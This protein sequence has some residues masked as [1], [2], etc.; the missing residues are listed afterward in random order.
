MAQS[1][2]QVAISSNTNIEEHANTKTIKMMTTSQILSP[3]SPLQKLHTMLILYIVYNFIKVKFRRNRK[4]CPHPGTADSHLRIY[5]DCDDF[6][7][8]G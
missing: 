8:I 6:M 7:K 4:G 5:I 2:I 1:A 3:I